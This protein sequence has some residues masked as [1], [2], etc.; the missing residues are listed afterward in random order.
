MLPRNILDIFD[1]GVAQS[2]PIAI[3]DYGNEHLT[4]SHVRAEIT[5]AYYHVVQNW[6]C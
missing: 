4:I 2:S 1:V 6:L 3:H 5:S